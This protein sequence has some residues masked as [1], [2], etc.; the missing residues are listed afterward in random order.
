MRK[1]L[2]KVLV[3]GWE[4][5][6]TI[7]SAL[8]PGRFEVVTAR[9]DDVWERL[10]TALFE[11]VVADLRTSALQKFVADCA[12]RFP[13]IPVIAI[14]KD[15]EGS[16]AEALSLG[17]AEA[18]AWPTRSESF[19]QALE[20][21]VTKAE[22]TERESCPAALSGTTLLGVSS[23]IQRVRELVERAAPG[24]ATV[25]IR[26]ETGTGKELVARLLHERGDRRNKPFIK[27]HV[28]ALPDALVES[29]L[30][31]SEKGA[32]TGAVSRRPGRVELAEG[33]TLFLDELGEISPSVQ[34][35]LLRLIQD[36]E[37]ER[38]GGSRAL[39]ANIRFIAATH[40]DLEHMCQE[41]TFREDLFYRLNV[42]SLW[43]PPLRAR[44]DD[45]P[46]LAA[47][48]ATTL[49]EK[50]RR[51]SV[52]FDE[53][54]LALLRSQRWPGNVRQLVNLVE[55]LVVMSQTPVLTAEHVR[56]ELVEQVAFSTQSTHAQAER[57]V[58]GTEQQAPLD[59]VISSVRPLHE[60][61]FRAERRALDKA[62]TSANG[63]RTLAA[64]L[65]GVSR[66]TLYTKLE[67]HGIE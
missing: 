31:G 20:R 9:A 32:F 43:L 13:E 35:K 67:Q 4:N 41:G 25:L 15:V 44:R 27:T 61:V 40:R 8:P 58:D 19:A 45:I 66:R 38:L 52:E 24:E 5:S 6:S 42:V 3:V 64:R 60:E 23:K 59:P 26:G 10:D 22:A 12:G 7:G 62:L 34:A 54:A 48:F 55:R 17:A 50:H 14:V 51:P 18:L 33:G 11:L 16:E 30:F 28:A 29:E 65:L 53:S 39:K 57:L 49:A 63:N 2:P 1:S 21:S 47:S 46:I 37:Y 36:R 56:S